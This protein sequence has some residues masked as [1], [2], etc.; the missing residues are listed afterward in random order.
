MCYTHLTQDE[1][2]QIYGLKK[3]GMGFREIAQ[4][5]GR[6]K[7]TISRELKRNQGLRGY[8]PN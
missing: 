4:K 5:T 2:Y 3:S 7:S 6:N 8:R 1:R